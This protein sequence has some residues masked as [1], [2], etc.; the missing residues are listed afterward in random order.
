M[1][2]LSH[3]RQLDLSLFFFG[4]RDEQSIF[5][6]TLAKITDHLRPHDFVKKTVFSEAPSN[7]STEEGLLPV[8]KTLK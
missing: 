3:Q 4:E 2:R 7:F 5:R 8:N 1:I 6:E